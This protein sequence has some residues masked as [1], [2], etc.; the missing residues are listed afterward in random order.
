MR[1]IVFGM[2][3]INCHESTYRFMDSR[4]NACDLSK[5]RARASIDPKH[6]DKPL[7]P[8]RESNLHL[9]L[10]IRAEHWVGCHGRNRV[11]KRVLVVGRGL[12]ELHYGRLGLLAA[13]L[14]RSKCVDTLPG[15]SGQHH[16]PQ[17]WWSGEL[18]DPEQN[19][20]EHHRGKPDILQRRPPRNRR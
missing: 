5:L 1:L 9:Q 7:E 19:R 15:E 6:S 3:I 11:P 12:C 16:K 20:P 4:R 18:L 13:V 2:V 8:I 17:R 10:H 14:H